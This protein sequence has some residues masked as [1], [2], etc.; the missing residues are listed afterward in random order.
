MWGTQSCLPQFSKRKDSAGQA[1]ATTADCMGDCPK[2][3]R[4]GYLGSRDSPAL[5]RIP[6][7]AAT[8]RNSPEN[9]FD[10]M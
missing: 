9:R 3:G 4:R 8:I 7:V 5:G 2:I 6:D 1:P 10:V